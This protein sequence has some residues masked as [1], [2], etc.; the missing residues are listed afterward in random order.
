MFIEYTKKNAKLL[1]ELGALRLK[2]DVSERHHL[3]HCLE[4]EIS[5]H[6]IEQREKV[7]TLLNSLVDDKKQGKIPF[8]PK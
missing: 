4:K 5:S 1:T 2:A 8:S 7:F 3:L 6:P